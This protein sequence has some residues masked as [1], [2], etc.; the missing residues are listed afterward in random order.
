MPILLLRKRT[1]MKG[2]RGKKKRRMRKRKR[3]RGREKKKA[4]MMRREVM[5]KLMGP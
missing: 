1:N 3:K 2:M 4:T 5:R